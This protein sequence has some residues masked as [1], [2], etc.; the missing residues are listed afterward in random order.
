MVI[1]LRF[2]QTFEE[3]HWSPST[4]ED[5]LLPVAVFSLELLG[6][7][8]ERFTEKVHTVYKVI[9][10]GVHHC[11]NQSPSDIE[12]RERLSKTFNKLSR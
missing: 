12:L 8:N 7:F 4:L 6:R 1:I 10:K 5:I 9:D 2:V 11:I 3:D